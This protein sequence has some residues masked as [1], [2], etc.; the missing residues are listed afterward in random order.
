LFF[1]NLDDVFLALLSRFSGKISPIEFR[2]YLIIKLIPITNYPRKGK[3]MRIL[4]QP[5]PLSI[6]GSYLLTRIKLLISNYGLLYLM[7]LPGLVYYIIFR[8]APMYGV[9]IAFKDYKILQGIMGSPWIGFQYFLELFHSPYFSRIFTNSLIISTLKLVFA[10]SPP[11]ILA[12]MLN[13]VRLAGFKRAVQTATYLP[14]FISWV[15]VYGILLIF[16]SPGS[17]LVNQ[18][19]KEAGGSPIPFMTDKTWFIV[20]ILVSAIWKSAGMG[21]VVYLAAL[22]GISPELYESATMDG[23]NKAQ[24]TWYIS[25]PGI[26]KVI[27]L[28]LIISL[29]Y[30]LDAGFDQI[31]IFY[32]PQVYQV[33]DIIDTWV[34]RNGIEQFHFSIATA[35]GLFKSVIGL[36]LIFLSNIVAKRATG[37][38]IW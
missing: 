32:N 38:G 23:A 3:K 1:H 18:Y 27:V 10:F 9:V 2:F 6:N 25:L 8:Y 7:M 14:Y 17:G 29:G 16:L 5:K 13:D 28:L 30:I 20:I 31:Y 22:S 35:A 26:Q 19:I 11:I 15:I 34:F 36:F 37:S 12:L 4:S 21:A 24:Q 33:A